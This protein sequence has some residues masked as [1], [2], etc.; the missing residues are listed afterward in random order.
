MPADGPDVHA[1][2]YGTF[3]RKI[4][5]YALDRSTISV[6]AAI[7]SMTSLPAQIL[8]LRDRGQLREGTVADVAVLDLG[9][10]RDA[11]TFFD[12]HRYAEG[13]EYVWVNGVTVVERGAP[14]WKLPGRVLLRD[15]S[16]H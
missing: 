13:V 15:E 1:R 6:E 9:K 4:R 14:T 7:R 8:G 2:Y 3:P 16:R 11:S 10:L 5:H 12:P